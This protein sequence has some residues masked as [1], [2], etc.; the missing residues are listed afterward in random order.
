MA[1]KQRKTTEHLHDLTVTELEA[2]LRQDL[3]HANDAPDEA[4]M[5]EVTAAILN[6][7]QEDGPAAQVDV[8]RAWAEFQQFY[9]EEDA[10]LPEPSPQPAPRPQYRLRRTA[11]TLFRYVAAAVL[12]SSLLFLTAFASIA[13]VRDG[14]LKFL[15]EV[16]GGFTRYQLV[17]KDEGDLPEKMPGTDVE[18]LLGYQFPQMPEGFSLVGEQK[19]T[20]Q[21]MARYVREDGSEIHVSVQH[22][23]FGSTSAYT[24]D[25]DVQSVNIQGYEGTL[26]RRSY[27]L[28]DGSTAP[29]SQLLWGNTEAGVMVS[30]TGYRID[31]TLLLE[32]AQQAQWVGWVENTTQ[33]VLMGCR[34]PQPPEGFCLES[35]GENELAHY[36]QYRAETT[37]VRTLIYLRISE[38]PFQHED[39]AK[40]NALYHRVTIGELSAFKVDYSVYRIVNNDTTQKFPATILIWKDDSASDGRTRYLWL[41]GCNVPEET[42]L[43]LAEEIQMP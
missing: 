37:N 38:K 11:I 32:L 22:F 17:P 40:T 43:A 41:E 27:L 29:W 12:V 21:A 24:G 30:L 9:L 5:L 36:A 16:T 26:L 15:V 25:A 10:A 34:L 7:E 8:D 18:T 19:S 23:L 13:E 1:K 3:A 31:Y 42:L 39:Y 4:F 14:T 28:A 2:L 35:Y 33:P 20:N 6:K